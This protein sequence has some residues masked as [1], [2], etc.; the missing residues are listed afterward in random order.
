[1]LF[2]ED[3]RER[4]PVDLSSGSMEPSIMPFVEKE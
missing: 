4:Y 3:G 2:V 1:M